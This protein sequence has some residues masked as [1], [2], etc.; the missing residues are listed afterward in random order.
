LAKQFA[1]FPLAEDTQ[2]LIGEFGR[3]KFGEALFRPK[4]APGRG[5]P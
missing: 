2:R 3:D 4:V 5:E 1:D